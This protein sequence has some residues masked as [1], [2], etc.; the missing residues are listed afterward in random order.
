MKPVLDLPILIP[1][2]I[3]IIG[4]GI[5][6]SWRSSHHASA[7]LRKLLIALRICVL[8]A[9]SALLLNPGKWVDKTETTARLYPVMVDDSASMSITN[10]DKS[11]ANTAQE[12]TQIIIT[13]A[14]TSG[15]ETQL[16]SFDE[17]VKS[18]DTPAEITAAGGQSNIHKAGTSL[19]SQLQA[20]G[21][22]PEAILMLTDGRQTAINK[23]STLALQSRANNAPIYAL[24][25]GS[26]VKRKDIELTTTRNTITAFPKQNLQV[27]AV[28]KSSH[29]GEQNITLELLDTED[30]VVAK[31]SLKITEEKSIFHTF[32]VKAPENSSS[33][34][35]RIEPHPDEQLTSNNECLVN[36]RILNTKT[37]V[38]IAEGAPY[39]DSKFL[40][41]LLR[42]QAH[43]DVHSVHRLRDDRWFRI[44]SG[45]S[46]P[47][48]SSD[49][50]FP[51]TPE[52]LAKYDLII[53]GK[54]SEFFLTDQRIEALKGFVRDQGGAILFSRGKP[55]SGRLAALEN[56]EPVNWST[57]NTSAFNLAP[58]EDGQSAGLFGRALPA[59]DSPIWQ[60]LPSLK[61]AHNIESVKP[62][63]RILAE[64]S[65]PTNQAKFPLLM[66]R[67]Y[68]QGATA[69]V[70]ADGLWKWDFYP[71]ARE[72][73]N[74][75]Q[76]FWTQLIQWVVAYS[77]FLPGHDYSL[78]ASNQSIE[79]NDPI[80]FSLSYRGMNNA[81]LNT[82]KPSLEIS[83][84]GIDTISLTP[85]SSAPSAG[86]PTW[87]SS[88]T[89][90]KPGA[91]TAKVITHDG[92]PSP[93]MNFTVNAP[94]S[95]MDNL[96]P[97]PV[98]LE[99][100]CESTGGKLLTKEELPAFL[101]ELFSNNSTSLAK[102]ETIWQS[103]WLRW[104]VPLIILL[105][106]AAEWWVRRRNGLI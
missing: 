35:L 76:E 14:Q 36:T 53:F 95:E 104:F 22:S 102:T 99:E 29:L 89:A 38:F 12:T 73:G 91:Y 31:Q 23:K 30:K 82:A 57:G 64:G 5:V 49:E 45:Q 3:L 90:S 97:D 77:E 21:R 17:N 37:R 106:L 48:S 6:A 28:I 93:V 13:Q 39:W 55:Y 71:E 67:R 4:V 68:G 96:D 75:Y 100:L 79:L 63:T 24:S 94:P 56:L 58:T 66:V 19:F 51:D 81:A 34:K 105:L 9:V 27:T 86:K 16:F 54:N 25:I 74:M 72:L 88:F 59:P 92:S 70:N 50:V 61:D 43:M 87:K 20:S 18:I 10:G 85:A 65:L 80:A 40:A 83:A 1:I 103:S 101:K 78:H 11:R 98:F 33:Y 42:Q 41:Q 32:S 44:D 47:S 69:L 15:V 52:E 84:K 46:D 62:F 26:D 2:L 8:L 7:G 60:S